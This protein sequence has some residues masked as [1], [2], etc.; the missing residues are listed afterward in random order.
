[1]VL[2]PDMVIFDCDG[3]LVDSETLTN[4][5]IRDNLAAHGLDLTL[6]KVMDL[7]VGGTIKSAG[8]QAQRL[9]A[10]LPDS[11]V[12]AM[13]EEIF[14]KLATN[15]EAVP[16]I[17]TVLAHLDQAQIP[18]AVGS[19]GPHKKMQITLGRTNL[20]GR[21]EGRLYS[22]EDVARP[23]PAPDVYLKAARDA[24][25]DPTACVVIE[26]SPSGARAAKAAG[27]VCFGF[28]AETAVDRLRPHCDVFFDDMAVLPARLGLV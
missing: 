17:E 6:D 2:P 23:K 14:E 13:Y 16:G 11:W 9:G 15:V 21:F 22:R 7:F 25:I 18:Y 28:V 26:D 19:N 4:A 24:G 1:M 5:A 10:Q 12:D 20:L 8:E 27:M 3:V